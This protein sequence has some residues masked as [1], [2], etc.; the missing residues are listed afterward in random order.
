MKL[1]AVRRPYCERIAHQ[2]VSPWRR[3]IQI[4]FRYTQTRQETVNLN[5]ASLQ[6][7]ER[8]AVVMPL[9]VSMHTGQIIMLTKLLTSSDLRFYGFEDGVP[10]ERWRSQP[11]GSS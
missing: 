6:T 2:F 11:S 3:E 7:Q 1:S 9:P 5:P 8:E 4:P 10:V